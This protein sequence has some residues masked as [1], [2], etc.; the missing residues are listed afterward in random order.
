M[1]DNPYSVDPG[2][3][4]RMSQQDMA[5]FNT[6]MGKAGGGR[7]QLA[8]MMAGQ[9]QQ[10]LSGGAV[11]YSTPGAPT[12]VA[13]QAGNA[14][15][16][17]DLLARMSPTDIALFRKASQGQAIPTGVAGP[18]G[19]GA[20]GQPQI[21]SGYNAFSGAGLPPANIGGGLYGG[22]YDGSQFF[23]GGSPYTQAPQQPQSTPFGD[24]FKGGNDFRSLTGPS[25]TFDNRFPDPGGGGY[26]GSSVQPGGGSGVGGYPPSWMNPNPGS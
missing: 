4:G 22:G 11:Q 6:A 23:G 21:P 8:G 25:E 20:M 17:A 15:I 3:W 9:P 16:P 5:A 1:V 2:L 26:G 13:P 12:G 19:G 18:Y 10:A 7:D 14:D 24:R